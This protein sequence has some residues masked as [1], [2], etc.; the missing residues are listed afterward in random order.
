MSELI[1]C[2]FCGKQPL[3]RVYTI[4]YNGATSVLEFSVKCECGIEKRLK[5]ELCGTDFS[6]VISSIN[7]VIADWNTRTQKER[8]RGEVGMN[9]YVVSADTYNGGWGSEIT[10]LGI[11]DSLEKAEERAKELE[12]KNNFK[13]KIVEI[14]MNEKEEKYIGGY[15]E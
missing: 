10:L 11:Y 7:A 12:N 8:K 13:C 4:M 15:I 9:L 1:P 14:V 3:T 2:P 6:E 5:L